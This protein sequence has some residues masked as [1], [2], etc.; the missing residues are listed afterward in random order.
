MTYNEIIRN[1]DNKIFAP[2]YLFHGDE[3]WYIDQLT[4]LIEE[5][6]LE[7][8]MRDFNQS[9][10]YGYDVSAK[11][12]VD[13][14]RQF[15]MMGNYQV[16]IVKEAQELKSWDEIEK[17][18]TQPQT[19]TILVFAHK[20]R[21]IDKRKTFYK[22]INS[23]K[24]AVVFESAKLKENKIPDFIKELL[25]KKGFGIENNALQLIAEYLGNDLGKINNEVQKLLINLPQNTLVNA[26]HIEQNIGISKDFNIFELQK[27]LSQRNAFKAQ[28]IVNYFESNP[29]EN[30]IQM[31]TP[32]LHNYFMR[33]FLYGNLSGN[34][35]N[36]IASELGVSPYFLSE[37]A[38]A[39]RTFSAIKVRGII[40]DLRKLDLK[41]KGVDSNDSS[42]YDDLK[43]LVYKILN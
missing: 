13:L 33:V 6:V 24:N 21:K 17:Y 2:V 34:P 4:D 39:S 20:H 42:G 9:V 23:S 38:M 26:D 3:P 1:V 25:S 8:E 35:P 40:S 41:S 30:P 10:V 18:L 16:V 43:V 29:K 5:S 36:T 31:L 7:P 22:T 11:D 37:Y 12:V 19:T 28:Q 15:P 32:M 14:A 27:A